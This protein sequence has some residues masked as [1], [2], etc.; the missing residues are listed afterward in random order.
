MEK[1]GRCES[2][3]SKIYR[4]GGWYGCEKWEWKK[5]LG[6]LPDFWPGWWHIWWS[7]GSGTENKGREAGGNQVLSKPLL[8]EALVGHPAG[9]IQ[10]G[11]ELQMTA[12]AAETQRS[13][14]QWEPDCFFSP[15][16]LRWKPQS[17]IGEL[18]SFLSYTYLLSCIPW[19]LK[20]FFIFIQSILK[21]LLW[22][23]IWSL[24]YLKICFFFCTKFLC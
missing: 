17:L 20:S 12:R 4:L 14:W 5:S 6:L 19:I 24:H 3:K 23:L 18:S 9:G 15:N 10:Q 16:F 2:H 22:F 8:S 13:H 7:C 21:F 11:L 1:I